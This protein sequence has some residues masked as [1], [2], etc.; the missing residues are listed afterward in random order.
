M[1][2]KDF[3][4]RNVHTQMNTKVTL[5]DPGFLTFWGFEN[6]TKSGIIC[7]DFTCHMLRKILPCETKGKGMQLLLLFI[8]L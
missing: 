5:G 2:N 3:S 1:Y 8:I 6:E 4:S 7:T